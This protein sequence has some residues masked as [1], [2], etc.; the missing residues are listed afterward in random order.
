LIVIPIKAPRF[1][2]FQKPTDLPCVGRQELEEFFLTTTRFEDKMPKFSLG[3]CA[4][5]ERMVE[6]ASTIQRNAWRLGDENAHARQ[7]T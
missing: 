3:H 4:E 1:E 7:P 6:R 2:S 5:G